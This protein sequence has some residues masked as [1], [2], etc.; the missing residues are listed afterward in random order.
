MRAVF[1]DLDEGKLEAM[2]R[3]GEAGDWSWDQ[4]QADRVMP[5]TTINPEE[6]NVAS[7]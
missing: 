3:S 1:T 7:E 2:L 6:Y 5:V 4:E